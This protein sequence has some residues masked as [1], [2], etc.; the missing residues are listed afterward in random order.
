MRGILWGNNLHLALF[1]QPTEKS[2][3]C[4]K[5]KVRGE[6]EEE[7]FSLIH[8]RLVSLFSSFHN[9]SKQRCHHWPP[10]PPSPSR[11]ERRHSYNNKHSFIIITATRSVSMTTGPPIPKHTNSCS[12]NSQPQAQAAPEDKAVTKI[13]EQTTKKFDVFPK[14]NI[15]ETQTKKIEFLKN[16]KIKLLC[17]L[18]KKIFWNLK[19]Y[20]DVWFI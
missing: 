16:I 17:L 7:D 2:S 11:C 19:G 1:V 12:C 13:Q 8:T 18:G 5:C 3:I 20:L 14:N 6:P 15:L 9:P 4:S 10:L